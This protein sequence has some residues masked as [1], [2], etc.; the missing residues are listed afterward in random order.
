MKTLRE[1]HPE[2]LKRHPE[3]VIERY[4]ELEAEN[5]KLK[6]INEMLTRQ[7]NEAESDL[8]KAWDKI[9]ELQKHLQKSGFR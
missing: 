7:L 2:G 8:T 3:F 9:E 5:A 4:R 1:T 6:E